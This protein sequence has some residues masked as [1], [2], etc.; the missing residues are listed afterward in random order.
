MSSTPTARA[1]LLDLDPDLGDGLSP[2]DAQA[3]RCRLAVHVA[4]L[5]RGAWQPARERPASITTLLVIDGFLRRELEVHGRRST[6]LLGPGATLDPWLA[7]DGPAVPTS[8]TALTPVRVIAITPSVLQEAARWPDVLCSL[9]RRLGA[10][11]EHVCGLLTVATLPRVEDRILSLLRLMAERWGHV[12]PEGTVLDVP[13]T[14]EQLGEL[15]GARRPTVTLGLSAL[16]AAGLVRRRRR[17][18]VWVLTPDQA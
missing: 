8:W 12:T 1:S 13:L 16:E 5:E 3:A 10:W 6:Q 4:A 15:I 17:D 9:I 11:T 7:A 14:H 18:G 2:E